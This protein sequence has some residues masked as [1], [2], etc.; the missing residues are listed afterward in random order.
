M[1]VHAVLCGPNVHALLEVE[2]EAW[3]AHEPSRTACPAPCRAWLDLAAESSVGRRAAASVASN[4]AYTCGYLRGK[5]MLERRAA[6]KLAHF[7][8]EP[9]DL[10]FVIA[11]FLDRSRSSYGRTQ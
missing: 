1:C 4:P 10:F 11:C 7:S 6:P 8:C 5:V 3:H 9:C 2:I